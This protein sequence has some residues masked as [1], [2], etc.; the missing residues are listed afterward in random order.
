[1]D[2][3]YW[4][5]K[6]REQAVSMRVLVSGL[7][8]AYRQALGERGDPVIGSPYVN[9]DGSERPLVTRMMDTY[10]AYDKEF[11]ET[12]EERER[13]RLLDEQAKENVD[14]AIRELDS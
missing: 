8:N 13:H 14:R 5:K 10:E 2:H 1:M 3:E 12:P 9:E 6:H 4:A 11:R 7:L